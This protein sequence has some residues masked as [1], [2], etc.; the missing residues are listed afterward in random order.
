MSQLLPLAS[1]SI[2]RWACRHFGA[3][4]QLEARHRQTDPS[5]D[6]SRPRSTARRQRLRS[7]TI[8]LVTVLAAGSGSVFAPEDGYGLQNLGNELRT[9]DESVLD[10]R[11]CSNVDGICLRVGERKSLRGTATPGQET[12][13]QIVLCVWYRA[14]KAPGGWDDPNGTVPA[15]ILIERHLYVV[16]CHNQHDGSLLVGYPNVVA[17]SASQR[18]PGGVVDDLEV[19]NYAT[20]L[21]RLKQPV[22]AVAPD[23]RQLVGT[24]TWFAVTSR[25]AYPEKS[26]QAGDTWATVRAVFSHADWDFGSHG[27]LRCTVD[28]AKRWDPSLSGS[29]QSSSC[30]KV[31]TSVPVT[32]GSPAAQVTVAWN[33]YWKSS[34]HEGWRYHST[35]ELDSFVPLRI[36]QLQ[37]VIR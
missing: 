4:R 13:G 8:L 15:K 6:H 24:E 20:S 23:A 19:A 32:T 25:L 34:E 5:A 10:V 14:G 22:A 31:F 28:A 37:A 3:T 9:P 17:Y 12:F 16:L 1:E 7:C 2:S 33:I 18:L 26:A 36:G 30:T 27:R 21:L 11:S 29:H 35:F